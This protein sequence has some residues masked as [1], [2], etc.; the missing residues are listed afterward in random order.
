M[1][2]A[3]LDKTV[4]DLCRSILQAPRS[5]TEAVKEYVASAPDMSVPGAVEYARNLHATIN[6]AIEARAK[7]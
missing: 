6:S 4:D 3:Q 5:A 2:E 7:R 1:P